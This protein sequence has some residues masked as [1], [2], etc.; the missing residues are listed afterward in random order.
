MPVYKIKVKWGKETFSDIEVNTDEDPVLFKAQLFTLTG[1]QPER[2]KVMVKG[3]TLKDNEWGNIKL[4]DGITVLLMGSKEEDVPSEPAQKPVFVEDMNE[5]ELASAMDFPAGLTNLGNTCYMNATIQCLKTV[6]ELCEALQVYKGD[7]SLSGGML[8]GSVTSALRDLYQAMDRGSGSAI[9]PFIL[10]QVLHTAFPRF[11]E[12]SSHG[13]F[14]QQ[15]A[16]ECWTEILRMLQQKLVANKNSDNTSTQF[17]SIIDQYFGGRFSCELKCVESEEEP[18]TQSEENFLQ[19]SCFISQDVKYLHS[20]LKLRLNEQITKQSPSLGRDAV[21][22]KSSKINRLPAYLSVK[23]MRFFYKE[24]ESINAKIL[25]DIKFPLSLDVFDLCSAELQAK[26]V[27]MR[28]KFKELEDRA[29]EEVKTT[30]NKTKVDPKTD[31]DTKTAPYWFENDVGSNNSGYYELQAVLTHKGRSS[32][33]G[34][35]VAWT[36]KPRTNQWL[37]LDDDRVTPISEEDVLKLSGGGDWHCAYVLLYGP[38]LLPLSEV[39]EPTEKMDT[40]A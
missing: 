37:Q 14:Q 13:G 7:V 33:S 27:P 5:D 31:C 29:V 16:D 18:S 11:A 20:G 39:A 15:D 38:R 12:K 28:T 40:E 24:K 23:F 2:Q 1:V 17:T 25:K 6:P 4:K 35:Y 26:L 36:R 30:K 9:P 8:A 32:G 19:L 21:Y 10:L 22:S 34:H 3:V